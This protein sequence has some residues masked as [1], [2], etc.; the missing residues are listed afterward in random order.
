MSTTHQ[1]K[2]FPPCTQG[3]AT[4]AP[5]KQE[6][7][8]RYALIEA[9]SSDTTGP[10]TTAD[11]DGNKFIHM[12]VDA[13]SGWTDVQ[14]INKKSGSRDA[15]MKSLG[16]I[17]RICDI[18]AKRLHKDGAKEQ[19]TKKIRVFLDSNGTATTHTA[20]NASQSNSFSE[21]RFRQLMAAAR[22]AMAEAPHMTKAF[23]YFAVLDAAGKCNFLATAKSGILS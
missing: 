12:L 7:Q 15:I 6:K 1:Q 14:L 2:S 22:T 23:W 9:V 4:R 13:Y 3:K 8:N 11:P 17:R 21:R 20:P 5:F 19:N 10:I 16:K 18:K